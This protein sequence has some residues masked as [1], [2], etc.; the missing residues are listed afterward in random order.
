MSSQTN[1]VQIK[2]NTCEII[3]DDA[4]STNDHV[5]MLSMMHNMFI[6]VIVQPQILALEIPM[7]EV[8]M[9]KT[10]RKSANIN[11]IYF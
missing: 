5:G 6:L 11:K 8:P 9:P 2:G 1:W 7:G 4:I 10:W 3:C